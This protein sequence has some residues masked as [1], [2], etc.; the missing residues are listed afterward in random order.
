[1]GGGGQAGGVCLALLGQ[2]V[3]LVQNFLCRAQGHL[4]GRAQGCQRITFTGHRSSSSWCTGVL[5]ASR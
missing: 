1:M 5:V 2:Q 3:V 4:T